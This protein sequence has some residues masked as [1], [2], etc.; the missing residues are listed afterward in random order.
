M[1]RSVLC[2]A[3]VAALAVAVPRGTA[4][5][6]ENVTVFQA[7]QTLI[8]TPLYVAIDRGFF[9][10]HGLNVT[11][12][13]AGS[14]ANAVAAV[15]SG[16]ATFSVQDPMTAGIAHT[17]GAPLKDICSVVAGVPAWIVARKDAP[18]HA[19]SDLNGKTIVAATPPATQTYLLRDLLAKEHLNA[20]LNYVAV[21]TEPAPLLAGKGDA[22]SVLSPMVEQVI[23]QGGQIVYSF[24]RTVDNGWAFSAVTTRDETIAQKPE[25]VQAFVD[26]MADAMNYVKTNETGTEDVA[27]AEFPQLAP[28]LVRAAVRRLSREHVFA[29]SPMITKAMFDNA[30]GLQERVGNIKPG[31][32]RYEEIIET[33]FAAASKTT[34]EL[35]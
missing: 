3:L 11:K 21:G 27:V 9:T 15:I 12:V 4:R 5:A 10:K 16:S 35:R 13:T 32:L 29:T 24:T 19:V 33:K 2:A 6:S 28:D 7:L 18:I 23:A 22:A 20:N 26:A 14:S 31:A 30:L 1:F 25:V 8:Y 17:K 34:A